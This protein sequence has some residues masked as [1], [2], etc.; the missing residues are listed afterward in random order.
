M[1]KWQKDSELEPARSTLR[2]PD[3]PAIFSLS[4]PGEGE[5]TRTQ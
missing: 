4:I 1:E 3:M 5:Y 2:W